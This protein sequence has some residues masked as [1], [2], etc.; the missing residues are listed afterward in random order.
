M[1][2][3]S[4]QLLK[5]SERNA[6][7]D[8]LRALAIISVVLYHFDYTLPFGYLGVDLFFVIS[9][10]LIGGILIK[11]FRKGEGILY[12]KFILQRGFKIWPSYFVF[13]MAGS[14]LAFLLYH[15]LDPT[16]IIKKG[17]YSRFIFFYMNYTGNSPWSFAHLW[18]ICVEEHF[19][20]L[21]PLLFILVQRFFGK[22]SWLF[23]GIG[24]VIFSGIVFK[25]L[26]LKF[27]N[28]Q[29]T[30]SATHNRIDALGWGVLLS[31]L[32]AYY[33][34]IFQNKRRQYVLI[35]AGVLLIPLLIY[36]YSVL[37]AEVFQKVFFHTLMPFSFFLIL[38]GTYF[39]QFASLKL[40]RFI[41][42]YSYNWYLWHPIWA[43]ASIHY[44]GNG[45]AGLT[46]FLLITFSCAL[47]FT[48]VIEEPFLAIR[49]RVLKKIFRAEKP[50]VEN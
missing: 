2:L 21:L 5:S 24:L 29:D 40:F 12:F 25:Y 49:G 41:A 46:A 36:F 8:V 48:I 4:L 43:V 28:S 6:S 3:K 22:K 7:V 45:F 15:Q 13:L 11:Q 16:Q 38:A 33:P 42:Y 20:I 35:L 50:A 31:V 39:I 17:D 34:E 1:Q 23:V 19:Y 27:T 30:Y 47:L 44:F 18:S 10:L 32:L 9:G 26:A 14:L 37:H